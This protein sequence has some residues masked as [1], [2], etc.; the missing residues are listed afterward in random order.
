MVAIVARQT[1]AVTLDIMSQDFVMFARARGLS[2]RRIM[3]HY[4]LRN[5]AVPVVTVTGLL[6][7]Y[8]IGGTILVEQVFSIEGLGQLMVTSVDDDRHSH[9]AR[10]HVVLRVVR[11]HRH[12]GRRPGHHV[13]RPAHHVPGGGLTW[14]CRS[15]SPEY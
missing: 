6:L 1:R 5:V 10:H 11:R 8:L 7:I 15:V 3:V 2:Q 4:A 14:P 9:G 12:P 13:D